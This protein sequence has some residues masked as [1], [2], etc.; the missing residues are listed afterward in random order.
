MRKKI[1]LLT[2]LLLV[3]FTATA[4]AAKL[5][6]K[7]DRQ[8][9]DFS[10]GLHVLSGNVQIEIG[11]RTITAGEARVNLATME[12]WASGGITVTQND[13]YF[14]GDTVYVYA[15]DSAEISGGVVL[16]RDDLKISADSVDYNWRTKTAVFKGNVQVSQNGTVWSA[17]TVTYNVKTNSIL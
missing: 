13:L 15:K 4:L 7:A 17:A 16:T 11:T 6:F 8:Y 3:A 9:F 1:I 10:T 2:I 12:V 14:T 5:S